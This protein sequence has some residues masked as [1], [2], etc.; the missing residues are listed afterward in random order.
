VIAGSNELKVA[1]VV[2]GNECR[3]RKKEEES[4]L[5]KEGVDAEKF[6]GSEGV[7]KTKKRKRQKSGGDS[8]G[9]PMTEN[10]IEYR[11]PEK[12]L[13]QDAF[14]WSLRETENS[15]IEKDG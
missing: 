7:T 14:K 5:E 12:T 15:T 8:H 10:L 13:A 6:A 9:I 2:Q 4:P 1:R 11:A 3:R